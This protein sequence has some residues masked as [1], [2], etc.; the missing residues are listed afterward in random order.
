MRFDV[1]DTL[2]EIG[3]IPRFHNSDVETSYD[4]IAKK[5][6]ACSEWIKKTRKYCREFLKEK[7]Q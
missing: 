1:V 3:L 2:L 4:R 5:V 6:S 7:T